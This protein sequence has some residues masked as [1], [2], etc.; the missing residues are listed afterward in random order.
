MNNE[1]NFKSIIPFVIIVV[2]ILGVIY[3]PKYFKNDDKY[4]SNSSKYNNIIKDKY[5]VNEYIAIYVDDEQMTRKYLMDYLNNVFNDI[6]SSY[7]LLNQEYREYK[8]GGV[9]RYKDYI[10][11]LN[12]SMSTSIYKYAT[13]E[14]RGYKY[15]DLYDK[16]GNRFIFR[17]KGVLQYEVLFEDYTFK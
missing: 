5:G 14:R 6:D 13:Y 3:L 15:Y 4:N 11:S 7:N 9:E 2:A 8:F 1:R 10:N 17:T 16:S 12:L